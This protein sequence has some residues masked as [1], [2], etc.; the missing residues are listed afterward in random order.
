ME[1]PRPMKV[2]NE[3]QQS[4]EYLS[5]L[6]S[7][8]RDRITLKEKEIEDINALYD[9]K[10]QNQKDVNEEKYLSTLDQSQQKIAAVAKDYETK[11]E[12][13]RTNLEQTKNK[14]ADEE[15]NLKTN[16]QITLHNAKVNGEERY[17]EIFKNFDEN[18]SQMLFENN[19][20]LN[21]LDAQTKNEISRMKS[22]SQYDI[23]KLEHAQNIDLSKR[24]NEFELRTDGLLKDQNNQL[25]LQEDQFKETFQKQNQEQK[26]LA[27]EKTRIYSDRI[28][29]M[30]K[31]HQNLMTQKENDFK[32]KY[33]NIVK[34][35]EEVLK[36]IQNKFDEE[37]R[38]LQNTTAKEKANITNKSD[39]DFY[40]IKTLNPRVSDLGKEVLIELPAPEHEWENVHL[41]V[42]G[43]NVK[44]TV[45]R[46]Y[47]DEATDD[48]GNRNKSSRS[49]LF[50]REF[51][52]K[53]LLNPKALTQK[54]EDGIVKFK[55]AKL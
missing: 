37:V 50:S 1:N 44:M 7:G 43:R 30:D 27:D 48:S 12:E 34:Q 54:Y 11:L 5:K 20:K 55:I 10:I 28:T 36:D 14:L 18:Q 41:S 9:R 24:Q 40:R 53:D 25:R 4:K 39:D 35:H 38:N 15:N 21:I 26:R 29:Y 33:Q 51:M 13:Y 8:L 31:F 49:E 2:N 6:N 19:N 46:K 23:S 45:G 22:R 16:Q 3:V 52:V 17:N 42:Q 47:S 32:I